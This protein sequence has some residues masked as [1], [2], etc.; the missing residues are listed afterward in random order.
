MFHFLD[1]N[2]IGYLLILTILSTL[3]L[4]YK[5][6]VNFCVFMGNKN[7][8]ID[9][10][11]GIAI[12][13]VV[14]GHV[15][16]HSMAPWTQDF[17]QNPVFKIIYTFHMP[18]FVFISGYL[19]ANSLN[20]NSV[21]E[22]FKS[23]CKSLFVPF[24]SLSVLG[25]IMIYALGIIFGNN[26][27]RV[28]ILGDL[29]DQLLLNP[30]VW[31]LFTLFVMSS[32]LLYSV[33]LEK[34]FGV[35]I[36]GPIYLLIMIIPYNNYCALY[37]IKWFYLFYAAGYFLNRYNIKISNTAL[38]AMVLLVSLIMFSL[39]VTYWT[40]NDYIYINKMNFVS[41]Q[42]FYEFL[43][44]IYRY[45]MGFLGIIIVFYLGS[46]LLKTKMASF[47]GHIGMYSLD[48]YI[49]QMLTLEG[50]YPRWIYK[51]RIH[52]DFSSPY[53][54]YIVAPLITIFFV[55]TC[56]L[57]SKFLIRKNYLLNKLLLGGRA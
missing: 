55:G 42:Y 41:T 36:F 3:F 23:R 50:I 38:K 32:V 26:L 20:R 46:C 2:R 35:I 30:L 28:D 54:L 11:K 9:I 44:V 25:G 39:L 24:V 29:A 34:H 45:I 7:L 40:K 56:V 27:G 19:M 47:L 4:S 22:V 37:Y 6:G 49:I 52:L 31:F 15:I 33:K 10:V 14:Y 8:T 48:I 57:I 16:E 18:L 13:L 43:R 51:A 12:I 5:G 17:F 53:V 21:R 1:C